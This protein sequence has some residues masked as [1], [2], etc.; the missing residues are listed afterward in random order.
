MRQQG[1]HQALEGFG[2]VA[3]GE[4]GLDGFLGPLGAPGDFGFAGRPGG[5]GWGEESGP[6]QTLGIGGNQ[7]RKPLG[8]PVEP[9]LP[10]HMTEPVLGPGLD[11]G[12]VEAQ[13]VGPIEGRGLPGQESIGG[14]LDDEALFTYGQ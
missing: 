10:P 12:S 9:S 7:S 8:H 5:P 2:A 6:F 3:P 14:P 4:E 1:L 13:L 11:E